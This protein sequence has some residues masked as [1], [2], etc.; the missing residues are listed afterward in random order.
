[1]GIK[2]GNAPVSW[3]I[4]EVE[5]WS[6]QKPYGAVLDEIKTAGY[7]G[8]ELG[9]Y[10]FFPIQPEELTQELKARHFELVAAFVPVPPA[11]PEKHEAGFQ[12]AMTVARLLAD[13]KAP[14]INL[15]DVMS[16]KRMAV[17][18]RSVPSRDGLT[19]IQWRGAASLLTRI[20]HAARR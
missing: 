2:V 17:A 19:Q 15:A 5:G 16:A 11:D 18:G 8:T 3:G 20:A 13:A 14:L 9:P 6:G 10:G 4:M 1:M 7:C 12:E